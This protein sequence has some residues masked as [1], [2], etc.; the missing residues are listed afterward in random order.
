VPVGQVS[1]FRNGSLL[2]VAKRSCQ[3]W[4]P[5]FRVSGS[6]LGQRRYLPS[7][8]TKRFFLSPNFMANPSD[9]PSLPFLTLLYL[10]A[11]FLFTLLNKIRL[12]P[13]CNVQPLS[14]KIIL[15]MFLYKKVFAYTLYFSSIYLIVIINP[16]III[17]QTCSSATCWPAP[18][19]HIQ[20]SL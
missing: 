14:Q 8:V 16:I 2:Q 10:T 7:C 1:M 17:Y 4:S 15:Y 11:P 12:F 19:S 20:K 13:I 9:T 18:V 3:S 6:T 5:C